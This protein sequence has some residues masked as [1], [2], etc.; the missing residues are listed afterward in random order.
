MPIAPQNNR[1]LNQGLLHLWSKFGDPSLNELS[2]QVIDTQTDTSTHR[3]AGNDNTQWPKR[4]SGKNHMKSKFPGKYTI[5][6]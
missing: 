3:D 5:S 4:A 1:D 2:K 6:I